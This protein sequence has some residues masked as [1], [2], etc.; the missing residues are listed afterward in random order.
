MAIRLVKVCALF[1]LTIA[2]ACSGAASSTPTPTPSPAQSVSVTPSAV[3]MPAA[4]TPTASSSV[5]PSPSQSASGVP[6]LSSGP[7]GPGTYRFVLEVTCEPGNAID[8]PPRATPPPALAMDVTVPAAGWEGA[9][10][11]LS[12]WPTDGQ[13]LS[14]TLTLGWTNF[15]VGLNSDP[16]MVGHE[17]PDIL[18]GP[19]VD[20]FVDAVIAH[21]TL[22]V[23]E[24]PDVM[25]G[26]YPGRFFS[27]TAPSEL[28]P[29]CPDWRPWDPGFV[30]QGPNARWDVWVMDV[31]GLRVLIVSGGYPE[32]PDDVS[33]QLRE[34]T[35]SIRFLP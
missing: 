11:F 23:T 6:P 13:Y 20:D 1:L 21:P 4:P 35:E 10:E 9:P 12:I 28:A 8:C 5:V 25:L 24:A 32:T 29:S 17:Q 33:A 2:A 18:V 34:M 15:H 31:N 26:G 16:C 27:V 3:P 14:A 7:L 19:T 30:A 22:E